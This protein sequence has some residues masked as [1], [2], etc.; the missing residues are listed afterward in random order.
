MLIL[1]NNLFCMYL[2]DL[3]LQPKEQQGTLEEPETRHLF[4][5]QMLY[6]SKM[7]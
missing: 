4:H 7:S 5:N 2:N 3:P 6:G 1:T